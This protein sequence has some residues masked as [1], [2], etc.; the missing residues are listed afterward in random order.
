M[1]NSFWSL[2]PP[3]TRRPSLIPLSWVWRSLRLERDSDYLSYIFFKFILF[4]NMAFLAFILI[5]SYAGTNLLITPGAFEKNKLLIPDEF[6]H[7]I[8]WLNFLVTAFFYLRIRFSLDLKTDLIP[9][10]IRRFALRDKPRWAC[11][12]NAFILASV[13]LISGIFIPNLTVAKPVVIHFHWEGS[14]LFVVLVQCF[15]NFVTAYCATL[16][17]SLLLLFEKCIRFFPQV[18]QEVSRDDYDDESPYTKRN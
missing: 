7:L 16:T 3:E 2:P 15:V 10:R 1:S 9:L 6:T 18:Q 5:D 8:R 14:L 11:L 17:T 13:S 4:M 12:A